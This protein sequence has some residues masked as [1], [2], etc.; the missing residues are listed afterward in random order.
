MAAEVIENTSIIDGFIYYHS[1]YVGNNRRQCRRERR[2]ECL[3]LNEI[4]SCSKK[5]SPLF[6]SFFAKRY[7][8]EKTSRKKRMRTNVCIP[9]FSS[10]KFADVFISVYW[11]VNTRL[12][13]T[14]IIDRSFNAITKVITEWCSFVKIRITLS[15]VFANNSK[16]VWCHRFRAIHG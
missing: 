3:P 16:L 1:R 5:D 13:I 12:S 11:S 9:I 8:Y 2:R 7:P 14:D 4:W 6:W 10:V 15:T